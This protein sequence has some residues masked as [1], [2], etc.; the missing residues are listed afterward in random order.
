MQAFSARFPDPQI[1]AYSVQTSPVFRR[2]MS[3]SPGAHRHFLDAVADISLCQRGNVT[4]ASLKDSKGILEIELYIVFN[5]ENGESAL[6]CPQHLQNIFNMLR[7]VPYRPPA[8]DGSPK[9]IANELEDDYIEICKAIHNF[10]CEKPGMSGTHSRF[11]TI[12]LPS[13]STGFR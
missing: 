6:G 4:M 1:G 11:F 9:V 10:D 7:Q 8:T 5:H 2:S 12:A 13:A 3:R